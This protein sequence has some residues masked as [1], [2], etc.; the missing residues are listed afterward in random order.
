M[1]E[2][3]SSEACDSVDNNVDGHY[4]NGN[5]DVHHNGTRNKVVLGTPITKGPPAGPEGLF[6][7]TYTGRETGNADPRLARCTA[8]SACYR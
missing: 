8:Y 6:S 5:L 3:G 1:P 2:A 7:C 4:I